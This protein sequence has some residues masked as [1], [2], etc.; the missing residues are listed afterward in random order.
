MDNVYETDL[1]RPIIGR[2]ESLSGVTY[3]AEHAADVRMRI[4]ADHSRSSMMLISDGVTPGNEGRGYVLRR[5][6]R[7]TV[8][9][10]RLLGVMDPV[11]PGLT[12]TVRDLM[13]PSYPELATDFE[14]IQRIA[15]KEEQAFLRTI[16]SGSKL[17]DAG[18]RGDQGVRQQHR[19]RVR[20]RSCCT[21]PRASRST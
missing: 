3:G 10:A 8:R 19:A 18:R 15:V 7:R 11:M 1:L 21:T 5:L 17:F 2:M 16:A 13:S 20:R 6:L 9:S 4:I 14:R 12:E